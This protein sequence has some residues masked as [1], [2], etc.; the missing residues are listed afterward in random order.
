MDP[1]TP[2]EEQDIRRVTVRR[3]ALNGPCSYS[4]CLGAC[5]A[6]RWG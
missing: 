5:T 3:W 4:R 2:D 1:L 6:G